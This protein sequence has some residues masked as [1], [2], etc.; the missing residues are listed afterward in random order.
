ML[1]MQELFRLRQQG[2]SDLYI[3]FVLAER[4]HDIQEK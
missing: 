1:R 2:T 3:V 4:K